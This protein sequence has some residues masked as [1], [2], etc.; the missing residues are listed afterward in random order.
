M[1][2]FLKKN[3]FMLGMP[4]AVAL[5]WIA[6]AGGATGGPLHAEVT[7]KLAVAVVFFIQGLTLPG[8]AL[9]DGASQGRLHLGVQGF[10][11]L[12]FPLL[13]LAMDALI[14]A[15]LSPDLRLGFLFLCVLPSTIIRSSAI[16]LCQG[17]RR[18]DQL[19]SL[20]QQNAQLLAIW[21]KKNRD[22]I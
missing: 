20:L 11:F 4:V 19:Y 7:T 17:G 5:A 16:R 22:M 15:N 12:V 10:C 8:K 6:P 3:W 14:G 1:T 18:H 13:G 21:L 9:V 2:A